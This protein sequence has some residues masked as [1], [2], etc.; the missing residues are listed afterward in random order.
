MNFF[1]NHSLFVTATLLSL[2][3]IPT[4]STSTPSLQSPLLL[5]IAYRSS[6][7]SIPTSETYRVYS[8]GRCVTEGVFVENARNREPILR[9]S[10]DADVSL[11]WCNFHKGCDDRGAGRSLGLLIR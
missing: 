1:I 11:W 10:H 2:L 4:A 9:V 3:L 5:E 7:P 8:D 6:H